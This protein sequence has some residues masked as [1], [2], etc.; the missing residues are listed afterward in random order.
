MSATAVG[1]ISRLRHTLAILLLTSTGA[2]AGEPVDFEINEQP[3]GSALNE[4]ARQSDREI[5]FSTDVVQHKEGRLLAGRYE[6]EEALGRLLAGTGLDYTVTETNTFLVQSIDEAVPGNPRPASGPIPSVRAQT[7]AQRNRRNRATTTEGNVSEPQLPLEEIIVTGTNIKGREL[8]SSPK[9]QFTREDVLR[10]GALTTE[11]FLGILPQNFGGGRNAIAEK[12]AQS[13]DNAANNANTT[14]ANLR[15]LAVGSTLT[16]VNGRRM[17]PVSF[18]GDFDISVIPTG[19]IERVEIITDGA[20]AVYGS[21]AIAGVVN[22]I[23]RDSTAGTETSVQYADAADSSYRETRANQSF[24]Q[25]WNSGGAFVSYEYFDRNTLSSA[26]RDYSQPPV[27]DASLVDPE[28]RHSFLFSGHQ[29]LTSRL[30]LGLDALY[31]ERDGR[32][33]VSSLEDFFQGYTIEYLTLS[34]SITLQLPADWSLELAGVYGETEE[35]IVSELFGDVTPFGQDNGFRSASLILNG[36]PFELSG[37]PVHLATGVSYRQERQQG[38]GFTAGALRKRES[39][40]AFLEVLVPLAGDDAPVLGFEQAELSLAL[41]HEDYSDFGSTTD[42]RIGLALSPMAGL[43][44]RGTYGT[45]FKAP[46]QSTTPG[47]EFLVV[48]PQ[49]DPT[50][51]QNEL[52][53]TYGGVVPDIGPET[54]ESW[55]LGLDWESPGRE[56]FSASLTYYDILFEGR[57]ASPA[58]N[59]L[60]FLAEPDIYGS[61]VRYDPPAAEVETL[62]NGVV[63][64]I[65][66]IGPFD[67]ND[68]YALVDFRAR[69]IAVAETNGFDVRI[70]HQMPVG[71]GSLGLAANVNYILNFDNR[72]LPGGPVSDDLNTLYRPLELKLRAGVTWDNERWSVGAFVNHAPS[73]DNRLAQPDER[74]ASYTTVD[75]NVRYRFEDGNDALLGGLSAYLTLRN[76]FNRQPPFVSTPNSGNFYDGANADPFGR[77]VVLGASKQW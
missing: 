75:T 24:G 63:N 45:S 48:H 19:A 6:P 71:N 9:F 28:T 60:A 21:D 42:P 31:T 37:R 36:A 11:A 69:N 38:T 8:R 3:L 16:L 67:P 62:L 2:L 10:A 40:A 53:I 39:R 12:A 29:T 30:A 25:E 51:G 23:L 55:T 52:V 68:V 72:P 27:A 5:L 18:G 17:A 66:L 44:L 26:D 34:P 70:N 35:R 7:S 46:R 22:F 58:P 1:P 4:F 76:A 50:T 65:N 20:S 49:L 33:K 56:G 13:F 61:F 15:G 47:A 32:R 57:I 14:T 73:Y 74:V 59:T 64:V 43:T 54:G 41:R 77:M